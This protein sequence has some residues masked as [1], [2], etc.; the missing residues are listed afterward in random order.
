MNAIRVALGSCAVLGLTGCTSLQVRTDYDPQASFA[1]LGTYSWV[2]QTV[3][4][5]GDPAVNS[6]LAEQRIQDAVDNALQ[7]IGYRRVATDSQDFH[8]TYSIA[9]E[10]RSTVDAGYGYGAYG[11]RS[12]LRYRYRGHSYFGRS[13]FGYGYDP[14][15][16]PYYGGST[17]REYLAVTLVL[18]IIDARTNKLIWRGWATDKLDHDPKPDAVSEYIQVAVGK[19][20]ETFPPASLESRPRHIAP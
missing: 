12:R 3:A 5:G 20:L 11:Y 15:Y 8:V 17:V 4:V 9:S 10:Q 13:R 19:I 7:R 16:D 2:D 18:D 6:T 14:Y 1:Q